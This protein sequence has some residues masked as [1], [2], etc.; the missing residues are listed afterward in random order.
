MAQDQRSTGTGE[1]PV[2]PAMAA[3]GN[4]VA[5]ALGARIRDLPVHPRADRRGA[6]GGLGLGLFGHRA[7]FSLCICSVQSHQALRL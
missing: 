5:H 1:V 4:A 6:A 7:G 2:G 3:I